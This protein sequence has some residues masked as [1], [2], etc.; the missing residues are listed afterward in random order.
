MLAPFPHIESGWLKSPV[1]SYKIRVQS[2][3]T[4][5]Q[6][7]CVW[8]VLKAELKSMKSSLA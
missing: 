8:I 5:F 2:K 7:K 3:V 6:Q 4:Q 1:S